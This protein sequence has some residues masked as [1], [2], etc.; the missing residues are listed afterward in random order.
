[1]PRLTKPLAERIADAER[2][3]EQAKERLA[4]LRS[5]AGIVER[6]LRTRRLIVLGGLVEA[7]LDSLA[8]QVMELLVR[9]THRNADREAI[10]AIEAL[11]MERA[12][13]RNDGA[14]WGEFRFEE[15]AGS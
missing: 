13:T 1:M 7:H 2:R 5:R 4:R 15:S 3:A 14:P 9:D 6:K 12:P 11:C 10:S 8:P